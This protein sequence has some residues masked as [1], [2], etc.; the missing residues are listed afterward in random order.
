[1]NKFVCF[2][3]FFLTLS[4][5]CWAGGSKEKQDKKAQGQTQTQQQLSTPKPD[6]TP[7]N[8]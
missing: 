8:Y 4:A 7:L 1:L 3:D 2:I 6:E 5:F